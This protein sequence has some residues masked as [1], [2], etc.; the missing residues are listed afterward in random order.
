ML[1][2]IKVDANNKEGDIDRSKYKNISLKK[3]LNKAVS[4]KR[5]TYSLLRILTIL[6]FAFSTNKKSNR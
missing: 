3:N 1:Y 6:R 5:T 2:G 4:Q